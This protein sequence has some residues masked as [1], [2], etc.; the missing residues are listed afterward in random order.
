[1]G[2]NIKPRTPAW[3]WPIVILVA[4]MAA[5]S[6]SPAK[7][8]TDEDR[9][10]VDQLFSNTNFPLIKI[11]IGKDGIKA[12]K[13]TEWQNEERPMADCTV[14]EGDRVYTNVAVHLKGSAGSF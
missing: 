6:P 10:A 7:P 2:L 11:E 12:L 14:R 13:K 9:K 1:M 4:V 5:V 8:P 3:Q